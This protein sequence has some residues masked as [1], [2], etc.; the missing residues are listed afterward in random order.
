MGMNY[1]KEIARKLET[2]AA[3]TMKN[4]EIWRA[5]YTDEDREAKRIIKEWMEN[6]G[7]SVYE[8][9][10]GNLF[11]RL[12]GETDKVILIGSHIDTVKNGGKYDGAAGIAT[13]VAALEILVRNAGRPD[14]TIE[15]VALAEEEGSRYDRSYLGSKGITGKLARED[16]F[17]VDSEGITIF[18]AMSGAGYSPSELEK[19][20]RE[21]IE[22]F[23][24]LHVEQGP[25][26]HAEGIKIGVVNSIVGIF[27]YEIKIRGFQNHAGTTPMRMR[28]DPVVALARIINEVTAEAQKIS[29]TATITFGRIE[30]V[31]GMSNVIAQEVIFT[32]DL[33]DGV[34]GKIEEIDEMLKAKLKNAEADGYEVSIKTGCREMPV[35]L[36]KRIVDTIREAALSRGIE[37]IEINSG[38]GHDAQIFADAIPTGMIFIPSVD[39]ISHSPLEY[40][41]EEDLEAG[42]LVL[43]STVQKLAYSKACD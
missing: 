21:D 27:S 25:V 5:V 15:V 11:G 41:T 9:P 34:N 37:F 17:D 2:L 22:A 6:A 33:R 36:D 8:D 32:V 38:A 18:D 3:R 16:L 23:V 43:L 28:K 4:G 29:D 14:K 35:S 30:T 7:L 24:E 39:G 31:P 20:V 1:G 42:M 40:T 19:V 13:A 10:M 26:L 12:Q